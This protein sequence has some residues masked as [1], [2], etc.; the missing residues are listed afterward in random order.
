MQQK[1]ILIGSAGYL[2]LVK[3]DIGCYNVVKIGY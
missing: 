3:N 2:W 1:L